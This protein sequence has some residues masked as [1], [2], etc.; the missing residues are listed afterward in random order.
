[1]IPC[2]SRYVTGLKFLYTLSAAD[3]EILQQE[4]NQVGKR[5]R[6]CITHYKK[7]LLLQMIKENVIAKYWVGMH[8]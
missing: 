4:S 1:M 8:F 2:Q 3:L 7:G 5:H 6:L